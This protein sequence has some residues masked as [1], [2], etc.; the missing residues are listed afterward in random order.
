[1]AAPQGTLRVHEHGRTVTFRV[2]G[3]GTM[4]QSLPLRRFAEQRLAAGADSLR[5]DL[6]DC[7]YMDST[8]LG[9]LLC[10]KGAAERRG[11][12][13]FALVEPSPPCSRLLRQMGL[14]EVFPVVAGDVPAGTA[15]ADLPGAA[16]D[17]PALKGNVE[18]AHR[19]LA[20][21]DGPAAEAFRAVVRCLDKESQPGKGP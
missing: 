6:R 8:F 3:R 10:L 17:V 9:T 7:A 18:Q 4:A 5:V 1:M 15:W 2:E 12:G 21:L 14:D 13:D 16:E 20:R 19:E 11:R